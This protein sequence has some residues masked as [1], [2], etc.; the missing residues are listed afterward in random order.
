M[1]DS[2]ATWEKIKAWTARLKREELEE[3]E[4]Y[5]RLKKKF[6]K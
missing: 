6:E 2:E 3:R 1:I 4:T 5:E